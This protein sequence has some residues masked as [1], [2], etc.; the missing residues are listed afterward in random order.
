MSSVVMKWWAYWYISFE[1][2]SEKSKLHKDCDYKIC[3]YIYEYIA[4][5][6]GHINVMDIQS[7]YRTKWEKWSSVLTFSL[8]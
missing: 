5:E 2:E 4:G 6:I 1:M 7:E 8:S 3:V